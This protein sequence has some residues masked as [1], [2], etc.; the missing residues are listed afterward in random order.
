M[1]TEKVPMGNYQK[2]V[3]KEDFIMNARKTE[4]MVISGR[5]NNL[6][7]NIEK[8]VLEMEKWLD[9]SIAKTENDP[10]LGASARRDQIRKHAKASLDNLTGFLKNDLGEFARLMMKIWQLFE[11]NTSNNVSFDLRPSASDL[12]IG[13][14]QVKNKA[15][16]LERENRELKMKLEKVVTNVTD[17]D[18]FSPSSPF[19]RP[20]NDHRYENFLGQGVMMGV[21]TDISDFQNDKSIQC[22]LVTGESNNSNHEEKEFRQRLKK[23]STFGGDFFEVVFGEDGISQYRPEDSPKSPRRNQGLLRN[24]AVNMVVGAKL[25]RMQSLEYSNLS[26]KL[27]G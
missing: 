12:V 9:Y 13:T 11:K 21:Q 16:I 18:A 7:E 6:T 23:S 15:T 19:K 10:N 2:P 26:E 5:S 3:M 25:N 14:S 4:S 17:D 22:E 1:H 8:K 20:S 27:K 24:K